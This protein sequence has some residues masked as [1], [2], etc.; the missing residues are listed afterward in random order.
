MI[1]SLIGLSL[2]AGG[3]VPLVAS[4]GSRHVAG[5]A[6]ALLVSGGGL[7][8]FSWAADV[9][10][11]TV[12]LDARGAPRLE[13]SATTLELGYRFVHHPTLPARHFAHQRLDLWRGGLRL[14]PELWTAA[15]SANARLRVAAAY[16]FVGPRADR[17][18]ASGTSIDL[19]GAGVRHRFASQRFSAYGGEVASELRID[20][21]DLHPWLMGSFF[22]GELGIAWQRLEADFAPPDDTAVLLA[23][24]GFGLTL[25]D[26]DRGPP[27]GE[28]RQWYDHRHDDVAGG[29]TGIGAGLPGHVGGD[30][31]VWLCDAAGLAATFDYGAAAIAGM[32]LLLQHDGASW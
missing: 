18:A 6:I 12:P 14:S 5:P 22:E 30:L 31:R 3:V 26:A 24:I 16:R 15:D 2:I 29:L 13:L 17:R 9:V 10:A 32:S 11:T 28:L 27:Y 25:G 7:F 21:A 4:G 23:R 20:L 1:T 8:G 19:R